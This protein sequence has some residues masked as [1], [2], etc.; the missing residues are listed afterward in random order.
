MSTGRRRSE[1]SDEAGELGEPDSRREEPMEQV[2]YG[3]R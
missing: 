2:A 3:P 1:A